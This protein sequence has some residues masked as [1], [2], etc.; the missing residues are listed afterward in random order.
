MD[1]GIT[2]NNNKNSIYVKVINKTTLDTYEKNLIQKD[3]LPDFN[4]TE[5]YNYINKCI[6]SNSISFVEN[7]ET[8]VI[9]L[10]LEFSG[11]K[12]ITHQI[13]LPRILINDDKKLT[14]KLT[15]Q[16]EHIKELQR[17]LTNDE[18]TI[19]KL[20]DTVKQQE[21][22]IT[23]MKNEKILLFFEQNN[24]FTCK[25]YDTEVNLSAFNN[26]QII[27]NNLSRLPN[28]TKLIVNDTYR[29]SLYE[30][31]SLHNKLG[32]K[33]YQLKTNMY[34]RCYANNTPISFNEKSNSIDVMHFYI[35]K[36]LVIIHTMPHNWNWK[37]LGD[38][39]NIPNLEK[40]TFINFN[41]SIDINSLQN[42]KNLK[43]IKLIN[44]KTIISDTEFSSYC[45]QNNIKFI[46]TKE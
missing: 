17:R 21:S 34:T 15:E 42:N 46:E 12:E 35:V 5:Y 45:K 23:E 32:Q 38:I 14:Y 29:T 25:K 37:E 7:E 24:Y 26:Y 28:L 10:S 31:G 2:V 8:L 20:I 39:D 40:I 30:D 16:E 6:N 41:Y 33:I 9:K 11:I 19:K 4:I 1:Y 27:W 22:L 44:C 18:T 3:I 36:E 13:I 43:E